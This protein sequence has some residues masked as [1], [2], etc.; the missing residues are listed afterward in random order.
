MIIAGQ[1]RILQSS[2]AKNKE[3]RHEQHAGLQEMI[4]GDFYAS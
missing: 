2:L 3:A 1:P 4:C